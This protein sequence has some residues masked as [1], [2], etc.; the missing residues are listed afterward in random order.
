MRGN[1]L[2]LDRVWHSADSPADSYRPMPEHLR[3]VWLE[4]VGLPFWAGTTTE[5]RANLVEFGQTVGKILAAQ[6]T[7]LRW[8]G[9]L[10]ISG[11]AGSTWF[12]LINNWSEGDPN[13]T[14]SQ[15]LVPAFGLVELPTNLKP[16]R[17][18]YDH[19][20][21]L[22]EMTIHPPVVVKWPNGGR[23][24]LRHFMVEALSA[25][26]IQA[27][28]APHF[29]KWAN[30]SEANTNKSEGDGELEAIAI[31]AAPWFN[32]PGSAK[33][34]EIKHI[35]VAIA[36]LDYYLFASSPTLILSRR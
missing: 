22:K 15:S 28:P 17:P 19:S 26:N 11:K 35:S 34:G 4:E 20:H 32:W 18:R 36:K 29:D 12:G 6:Q 13:H 1:L 14:L 7:R 24:G 16:R 9:P 5:D 23:R 30:V 33:T 31:A 8:S 10:K 3:L 25:E 21:L 27:W 2:S